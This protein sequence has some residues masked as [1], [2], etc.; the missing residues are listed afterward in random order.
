MN[1]ALLDDWTTLLSNVEVL[2]LVLVLHQSQSMRGISPTSWDRNT[3]IR[4][5]R[6]RPPPADDQHVTATQQKTKNKSFDA[7]TFD[8]LINL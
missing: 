7:L 1:G 8:Q 5:R 2:W 4:S 3:G 6:P